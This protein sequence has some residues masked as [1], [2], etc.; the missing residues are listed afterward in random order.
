[1]TMNSMGIGM[2]HTFGA[3][4]TTFTLFCLSCA[5]EQNLQKNDE[6]RKPLTI[7]IVY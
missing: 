1:M 4:L 6:N 3:I 5:A 2:P 7:R